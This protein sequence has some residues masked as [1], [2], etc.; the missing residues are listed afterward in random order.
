MPDPPFPDDL[1]EWIEHVGGGSLVESVRRPGGA[2]KE[3]WFVD[4]ER[5]DGGRFPLFLRYDRST[6]AGPSDPWTIHREGQV[7]LA[8]QGTDVPVPNVLGVHDR[9]Q[10]MLMERLDGENWFSRIADPVEAE[11]TAREFMVHLAALHRLDPGTLHVPALGRTRTVGEAVARELDEFEDILRH[12]GGVVNPALEFSIDWLRRNVPAADEPTRLV[13][14]DTGPGNFLFDDGHVVAIVDW[15]LAHL[16]DPMDDIAWL[17]LRTAQDAFPDLPARLR[18]YEALSGRSVDDDRVAYYQLMA[19]TKLQVMGHQPSAPP[20]HD[21]VDEGG[22]H[23]IGN[24]MIYTMLHRRLWLEALARVVGIER[25]EPEPLPA[26]APTRYDALSDAVLEQLRE[27]IVPRIGD[28]LAKQRAKGLARVIKYLAALDTASAFYDECELE[29]LAALLGARPSSLDDGHATVIA[30]HRR[31]TIGDADYVALLWRRV[32]R[33][34]S[35]M[36]TAMGALAE[37]H[38]PPLR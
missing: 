27:V 21:S 17:T 18:E 4:L 15:E 26:R 29:D 24:S 22:G 37:R 6:D 34:S 25:T 32:A 7:Y 5:T 1:R 19:E 38:W 8:L 16:G 10:A 12:R 14:G 3:A 11:S 35:L 9:H 31:G 30:E 33:E 36:A 13:Q 20:G 2:R 28:P 23:D